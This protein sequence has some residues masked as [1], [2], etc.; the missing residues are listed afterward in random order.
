MTFSRFVILP[1]FFATCLTL[2]GCSLFAEPKPD[3]T[4]VTLLRSAT[5]DGRT[6]DAAEIENE[7]YRLC[8]RLDDG[9]TPE[10]CRAPLSSQQG[11]TPL[12][13]NPAQIIM[14][15]VATVPQDS[16]G[17]IVPLFANLAAAGN[18]VPT[19]LPADL[20]SDSNS[21]LPE[22][23]LAQDAEGV[24]RAL[25]HELA[26]KYGLG[27]AISFADQGTRER[28][29]SLIDARQLRI[30]ALEA[31]LASAGTNSMSAKDTE[32]TEE[33]TLPSGDAAYSLEQYTQPIDQVTTMT[34]L[35]ELAA[36]DRSF[37]EST[38]ANATSASWRY[39]ALAAT[40]SA[41]Q[42]AIALK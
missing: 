27:V 34:F 10:S 23:S 1:A 11:T 33:H 40:G 16:M 22:E 42:T 35:K 4:L 15:N 19:M 12:G 3:P 38:A 7:I 6:E 13:D 37:W 17:V 21:S 26:A 32:A 20:S 30:E 31:T 24:S 36:D 14:D 25:K 18:A 41:A 8:G 5:A 28:I 9:T 2:G 39:Q 29:Q